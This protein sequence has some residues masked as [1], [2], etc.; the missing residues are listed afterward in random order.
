MPARCGQIDA[1]QHLQ[2]AIGF[3]KIADLYHR[4]ANVRCLHCDYD[5]SVDLR[6]DRQFVRN[7][8]AIATT[9]LPVLATPLRKMLNNYAQ[10]GQ[11]A[12]AWALQDR[13]VRECTKAA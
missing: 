9:F 3:V 13:P 10:S 6:S 2:I 1:L 4:R 8:H 5:L 12:R 11:A 7:S